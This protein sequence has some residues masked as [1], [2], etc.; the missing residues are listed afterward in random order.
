MVN[1]R[2]ESN[3]MAAE[4]TRSRVRRKIAFPRPLETWRRIDLP[5]LRFVQKLGVFTHILSRANA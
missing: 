4:Y 1:Q 3:R 2:V 5:G